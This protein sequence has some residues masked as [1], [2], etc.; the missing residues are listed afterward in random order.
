VKVP[1]H[2][3]DTTVVVE[4]ALQIA[5]A[6][7]LGE[8]TLA[9]VAAA[10]DVRAPSLYNHIDGR[11]GLLRLLALRSLS[12]LG[13]V[14]RDAAVGR[15]REDALRAIAHAYRKYAREHPGGYAATQRAPAAG[16]EE[17]ATAA[18]RVLDV[19]LAVLAG[20]GLEGDRALHQ[21]R[22]IRSA[23]HGFVT[24]EA[25]AGFGLPLD[26]DQSFELLI[27]T[28]LAGLAPDATMH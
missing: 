12:E 13:D 10:L 17:L 21:I 11:D 8:V 9:R 4:A 16:D 3:L 5:D 25:E 1:R 23:L 2:G 20:W 19:L 24:L 28:L 14:L 22:V 6:D 27:A 18:G 15:A 26:L 7:G